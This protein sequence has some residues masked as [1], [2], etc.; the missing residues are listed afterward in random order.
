M[1]IAGERLLLLV[2]FAMMVP[3]GP[4]MAEARARPAVEWGVHYSTLDYDRELPVWRNGWRPSLTAG[5]YVEIPLGRRW[6]LS[7]GLRY[8][9]KGNRVRYD[10][11]PS[12]D[13]VGEFRVVQ[14]YLAVPWLLQ[15]GPFTSRRIMLSLGPEV[16]FLLS[17]HLIVEEEVGGTPRS[18]YDD[19]HDVMEAIDFSLEAGVEYPF[20]LEN[21]EG[22]VRLRYSH[23]LAGVAQTT[24]LGFSPWSSNWSTRGI[25][26]GL[27]LRW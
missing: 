4:R 17:A 18:E 16:A 8:V 6:A 23:G 19:I 20:P 2:A 12:F 24:Q 5:A 14:N 11:R 25:Q 1:S 21:H 15:V 9:Q 13:Q 22:F 3:A 10:A 7:P 26:W 27:G